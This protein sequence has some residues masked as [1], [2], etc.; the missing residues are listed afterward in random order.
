MKLQFLVLHGP[1]LQALG[2][3]E[4]RLYGRETL[5]DIN[6]ALGSFAATHNAALDFFQSDAEHLL[7]EKI[8]QTLH[9]KTDC[10]LFNPA[11]FTHTSIALRDALLAVKK[12]FIEIHLSNTKA[13]EPFRQQSYFSDIALGTISGFGAHS[14]LLAL[15]A[16]IHHF[17]P[18]PQDSND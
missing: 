12:P 9:L 4:P 13:R 6:L 16:A 18:P 11:A 15:Q 2:L 17:T 5:Q 3:R 1:N 7:L 8:H 14:Y 10:I